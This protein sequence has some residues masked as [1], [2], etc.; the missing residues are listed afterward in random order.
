[1]DLT[2]FRMISGAAGVPSGP[3][4]ITFSASSSYTP[5]NSNVTISWAVLNAASVSIDQGI[6]SVGSSGSSSVT[7]NEQT[8]TYTL[9]ALGLDG[10]TSSS[11]IQ[12]QWYRYVDPSCPYYGT[13]WDWAC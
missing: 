2:T 8:K 5:N 13:R 10:L 11:T 3:V 7:G 12:I 6:G 9:T 1:M 4:S